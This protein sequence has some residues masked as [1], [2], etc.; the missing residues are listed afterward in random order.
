M[1]ASDRIDPCS[2][3]ATGPEVTHTAKCLQSFTCN[4]SAHLLPSLFI[5]IP[6]HFLLMFLFLFFLPLLHVIS[7]FLALNISNH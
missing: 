4:A 3:A 1:N 6:R 5:I 2:E 7:I